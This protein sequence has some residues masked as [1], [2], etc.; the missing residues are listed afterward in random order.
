MM[1]KRLIARICFCTVVLAL[2]CVSAAA[3]GAARGRIEGVRDE[4]LE[5][6]AKHNLTVARYYFERRKA[7]EGA[8][9]RLQEI[10]DI[11][12][13]FSKMDEVLFLLG[14]IHVKLN[15]LSEA[16]DYYNK[17]LKDFPD[18]QFSKKAKEQLEKLK[19]EN[20]EVKS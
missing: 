5:I 15:K 12:P 10:M 8:R 20:K 3:Q 18:S 14:E 1:D 7:Y 17:M 13:D 9:D 6:K 2:A 4:T 19:P 11:H 16:A